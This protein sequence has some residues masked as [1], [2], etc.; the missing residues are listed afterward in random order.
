MK[1]EDFQYFVDNKINPEVLSLIFAQANYF[2][3][4]YELSLQETFEVIN[5]LFQKVVDYEFTE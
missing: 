5:E 3:E 2:S 4:R 1:P